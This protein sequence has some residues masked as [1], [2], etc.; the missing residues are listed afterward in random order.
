MEVRQLRKPRDITRCTP[1]FIAV[2]RQQL[3]GGETDAGTRAGKEY[4]FH[5]LL[6]SARVSRVGDGVLAVAD[7]WKARFGETPKPTR[8]TRA[9]PGVCEGHAPGFFDAVGEV[10][11]PSGFSSNGDSRAMPRRK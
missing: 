8:E 5:G 4:A 9:L 6:G 3:R 2:F 10:I 11:G 7:F 1:D